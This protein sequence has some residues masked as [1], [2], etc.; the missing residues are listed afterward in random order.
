MQN[1]RR[2]LVDSLYGREPETLTVLRLMVGLSQARLAE[3]IG[4]S[5]PHIARIEGGR[6]D[7]GTEM[8][9]K[10]ARALAVN[11]QRAF[12]AIRQQRIGREKI[13]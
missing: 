4:T 10:L 9:A 12:A 3:M 1:A 13:R 5:Q 6:T 8:I 11:E 2:D 7:P